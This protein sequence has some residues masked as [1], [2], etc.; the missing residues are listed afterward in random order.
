MVSIIIEPFEPLIQKA[1][2]AIEKKI[3]GYFS[4]IKKIVLESGDP[5]HFGKVQSDQQDVIF[6]SLNKMKSAMGGADEEAIIKQVADT[7]AHEMGHIKSKFQGGEAPAE[8]EEKQMHD[9]LVDAHFK[10]NL[11]AARYARNIRAS[12]IRSDD[13]VALSK[14]IISIVNAFSSKVRPENRQTYISSMRSNIQKSISPMELSGRKKNPGA[15][16]GSAVSVI[17]NILAGNSPEVI[18]R[19]VALVLSGLGTL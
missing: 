10:R 17:K 8:T 14:S 11:R 7:L 19:T 1:I 18:S 12:A 4:G 9:R 6:I 16:I 5:G 3:P 2:D 13:P 15:G